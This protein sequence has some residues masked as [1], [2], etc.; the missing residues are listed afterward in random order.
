MVGR[1][2]D[3]ASPRLR[4]EGS[5]FGRTSGAKRSG[6]EGAVAGRGALPQRPSPP[7]H[8]RLL[9]RLAAFASR[10]FPACAPKNGPRVDPRSGGP[11][12]ASGERRIPPTPSLRPRASRHRPSSQILEESLEVV[13][14]AVAII[15]VVGMLP[16]IDAEDRLGAVHERVLAVRCLHDGDLAILDGK[17]GPAGTELADAGLDEI[18]LELLDR[19]EIGDDL[20]LEGAR[21]RRRRRPASS[22]SKNADGYNAARHC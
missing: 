8:P 13:G 6:G 7:P 14:T 17:P 16:H 9:R 18:L 4:G 2:R 10:V 12:P 22:T 3:P 15:D 5:A 21:E 20:L 1:A 11:L 19:A